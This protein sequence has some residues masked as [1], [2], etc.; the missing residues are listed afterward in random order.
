MSE[1]GEIFRTMRKYKKDKRKK[2]TNSS[3]LLLQSFG[4]SFISKNNGAHLIIGNYDF[5]PSTGLF[6][7]RK[8]QMKGRGIFRL[9]ELIKGGFPCQNKKIS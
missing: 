3:T 6:I 7:H 1:L 8:T 2:N 4:I 9:V 5:W